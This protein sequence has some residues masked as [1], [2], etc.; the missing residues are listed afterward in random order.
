MSLPRD[1]SLR[2]A[3]SGKRSAE[4]PEWRADGV[5]RLGIMVL[6]LMLVLTAGGLRFAQGAGSTEDTPS[7]ASPVKAGGGADLYDIDASGLDIRMVLEA[8]ARRSGAN[9]VV[10][11]DITGEI[12]AHL[13]QMSVDSILEHLSAVQGFKYQKDGSTYL[14]GSK[15]KPAPEQAAAPK[16]PP[17]QQEVLVW[18]CHHM[19]PD[20]VAATVEKVFPAVKIAE[21]PG[22]VT[23]ELPAASGGLGEGG[24]V[25]ASS[26]GSSS[27]NASKS[28]ST[29]VVLIGEASEIAK[30]KS[31]LAQL[32]VP[33]EQVEIQV[34]ITEISSNA[35]RDVGIQWSWSDI[36]IKEAAD[37]GIGF[38]KFNKEGMSITGAL[39]AL[40][41]DGKGKLL[42]QPKLSVLDNESAQILIGDRILYPKLIGYNQIGTP[43]YDKAEEKVGIYLQIAPKVAGNGEIIMTLYPQVSLVTGFLKT[44]A[45]DYPQ[46]STR[47]ARTTV[48]VKSGETLAIG[49][50]LRE[51]DLIN[52]AKFP[53][54]GDI[55][56]IGHLFRHTKKT[57]E[58]TE[59]VIL[60]S[61]K[62]AES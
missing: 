53:I 11:P 24:G 13:K 46:I 33:R 59:I 57:K 25:A 41:Q 62:I 45:G 39:S 23:P 21:A 18:E 32:D 8:L 47:E 50:L 30:V 29:R 2:T 36:A 34:A 3:Q 9:I 14:I 40:L 17:P 35:S 7:A 61:P 55:P 37:T 60:L 15:E 44:Q 38:G 16:P 27:A 1:L 49:G 6:A 31:M 54:L 26:A 43:L 42:A 56:I 20:Q 48:S 28:N 52:S 19:K 58:R 22:S 12:N 5:I 4:S 51:N 10:S